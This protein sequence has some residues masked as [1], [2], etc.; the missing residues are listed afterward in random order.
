MYS[1]QLKSKIASFLAMQTDHMVKV[2]D[3]IPSSPLNFKFFKNDE[4]LNWYEFWDHIAE[5]DSFGMQ[6]KT[7]LYTL[8]YDEKNF[9]WVLAQSEFHVEKSIQTILENLNAYGIKAKIIRNWIK[10]NAN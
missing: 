1:K 10:W 3:H 9:E 6:F 5:H 7:D 4:E 2:R 8:K